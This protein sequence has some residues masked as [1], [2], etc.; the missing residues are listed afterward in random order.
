M[1]YNIIEENPKINGCFSFYKFLYVLIEGNILIK[2]FSIILLFS[3]FICIGIALS[4]LCCIGYNVSYYLTYRQHK[5]TYGRIVQRKIYSN[6]IDY[7]TPIVNIVGVP[8]FCNNIFKKREIE[9]V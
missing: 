4:T 8:Q 3:G 2:L 5:I 9:Y 6:F 7:L 1:I